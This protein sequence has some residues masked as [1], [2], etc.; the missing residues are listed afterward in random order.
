MMIGTMAQDQMGDRNQLIGSSKM[1]AVCWNGGAIAKRL[2]LWGGVTTGLLLSSW[3]VTDITRSIALAQSLPSDRISTNQPNILVQRPILQL[4]SQGREVSQLQALLTL[5]GYYTDEIDGIY[6]ESTAIAVATFQQSIG[7]V[8]DGI[9]GPETWNRLLPSPDMVRRAESS[10][11]D[12][13]NPTQD[14]QEA[15]EEPVAA[16]HAADGAADSNLPEE[17]ASEETLP[18]ETAPEETAPEET[19]NGS[20]PFPTP[21]A[22]PAADDPELPASS[23]ADNADPSFPQPDLDSADAGDRSEADSNPSDPPPSEETTTDPAPE[24]ANNTDSTPDPEV[25][26]LPDNARLPVLRLGMRGEAVT[27]LQTRLQALGFFEGT[28]D[29]VFGAETEASVL[30]A[31]E[32]FDLVV[33]GIVGTATWEVLLQ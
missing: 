11:L 12:P 8:P 4:G 19:A 23:N 31:Q 15:S 28:V 5:L 26:D 32:F 10:G 24:D 3:L 1:R 9:M 6:Q 2:G 21:T 22:I 27:R 18:E 33:D 17:T 30:A 14:P 20:A 7:L 29:G 16:D 25:D 13:V